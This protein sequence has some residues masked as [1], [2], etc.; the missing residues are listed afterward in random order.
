MLLFKP[1]LITLLIDT[2]DICLRKFKEGKNHEYSK[3]KKC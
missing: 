2:V 1:V 3:S